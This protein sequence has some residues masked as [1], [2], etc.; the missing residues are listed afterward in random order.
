MMWGQPP[1]AVR[2]SKARR[3]STLHTVCSGSDINHRMDETVPSRIGSFD[4]ASPDS[5]EPPRKVSRLLLLWPLAGIIAFVVV[6]ITYP[7]LDDT[8]VWWV[9]AVPCGIS[10]LLTNF[11]WRKANSGKDVRPFFPFTTLLAFSCLFVPVVLVLNGAL[12]HSPVEQHRQIVT[13]TILSHHKGNVYYDLEL[14][15]WRP[16]RSHE[17]LSVSERKYLDFNVGDPVIVETHKGALGIPL[18]ASVHQPN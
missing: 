8:L 2:S 15:S 13:R 17:K 9:G 10:Y 12:D 6:V 18:L 5:S 14:T 16:Y 3:P 1:S 4:S 11:V 7:P